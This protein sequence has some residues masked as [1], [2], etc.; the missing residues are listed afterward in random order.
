M[1]RSLPLLLILS[2]LCLSYVL[3]IQS[4]LSLD[5]IRKN[6]V[7]IQNFVDQNFI[8]SILLFGFVYS[9]ATA[10]S[11][12]GGSILSIF[13][14]VLFPH[15]VAIALVAISATTGA[16]LLYLSVKYSFSYKKNQHIS[17][18]ISSIQKG[19]QKNAWSY[20]FF[21]RLLP[22]FPFW[23]VNIAPAFCN[24]TLLQY[25]VTTFLGILPGVYIYTGIGNTIAPLLIS[26]AQVSVQEI[27]GNKATLILSILAFVALL[28]IVTSYFSKKDEK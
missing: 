8:V 5:F 22:I 2:L 19:V 1:K 18:L 4:Y 23:I 13:A 21:I 25:T 26:S 12:P 28:P 27:I 7:A 17:P 6:Y 16:I 10:V 11:L 24:I 9:I 20:L 3:N 14:G 15:P